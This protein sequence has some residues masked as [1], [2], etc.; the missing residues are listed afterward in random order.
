MARWKATARA[1]EGVHVLRAAL[2]QR[3]D[4]N[5]REWIEEG[6]AASAWW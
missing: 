1:R 4:C 3:L 2:M 6:G 5:R